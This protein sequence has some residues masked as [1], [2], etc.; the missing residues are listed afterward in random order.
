MS[1]D[2]N[3]YMHKGMHV[4][5]YSKVSSVVMTTEVHVFK[6]LKSLLITKLVRMQNRNIAISDRKK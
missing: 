5:V 4:Y 3:I 1:K 2:M 6:M